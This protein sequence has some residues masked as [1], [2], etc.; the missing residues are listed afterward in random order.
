MKQNE[1]KRIR[2]LIQKKYREKFGQF[3]IEGLRLV[4]S[5]ILSQPNNV[6]L[7]WTESF[8]GHHPIFV[9]T[10]M[11]KGVGV[12][13]VTDKEI[14]SISHTETPS[15]IVGVCKKPELSQLD[16]SLKNNWIYLDNIS[17]PGNLG[18]IIRTATWFNINHIA[19]SLGCV[20]PYNPKTVRSGM[21]SHFDV[22]IYSSQ[23]LTLFNTAGY[24][25][26][27]ADMSGE[28]LRTAKITK[29]WT[30]V[31]GGE[32]HGLQHKV[33]NQCDKMLSIPRSGKGESLNVA[34][35][36]SIILY[37]LSNS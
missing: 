13:R 2:S 4:E 27:G 22:N 20:D 17:D 9:N 37:E 6:E 19:L 23:E 30:L 16:L 36:C 15:G 8:E 7:Y 1:Q 25:I 14:Q 12:T 11:E 24:Q 34:S 5:A 29:P 28:N 31:L 21:G 33:I 10:V 35:A 18:T 3:Q 26:I 32:A